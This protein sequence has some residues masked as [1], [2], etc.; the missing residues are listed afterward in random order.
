M[1]I[2]TTI[3]AIVSAM[4]PKVSGGPIAK[5]GLVLEDVHYFLHYAVCSTSSTVLFYLENQTIKSG[6]TGWGHVWTHS[7]DYEE[8][9][10]SVQ[11][12]L[13]CVLLLLYIIYSMVLCC[14]VLLPD[15]TT[16]ITILG[17]GKV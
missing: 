15:L 8:R 7:K 3:A 10:A 5:V 4:V 16:F 11:S 17:W 12:C 1:G 9:K 14:S 6:R 2:T 13:Y